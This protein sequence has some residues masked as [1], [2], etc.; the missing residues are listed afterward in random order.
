VIFDRISAVDM[1]SSPSFF[2]RAEKGRNRNGFL[3][4]IQANKKKRQMKRRESC[5]T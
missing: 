1:Y 4:A 3:S 2:L 5:E